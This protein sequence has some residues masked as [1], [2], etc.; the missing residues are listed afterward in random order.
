MKRKHH[1]LEVWREG[2][3]LVREVYSFTSA[4]PSD[5]RFGLV[6]QMRRCAVSVPSNIAEGAAR[7]TNKEFAHF[8]YIA[9]GSLSELETQIIISRELGFL[10]EEK[11]LN[12]LLDK[13]FGKLGALLNHIKKRND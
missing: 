2:I 11:Q 3:N 1:E 9:R 6:S 10:T 7:Q 5:E 13:L 12:D 8:L 4:F